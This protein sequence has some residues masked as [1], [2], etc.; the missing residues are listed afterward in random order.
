MLLVFVV[1]LFAGCSD[2]KDED[3]TP[4]VVMATESERQEVKTVE[5]DS[6]YQICYDQEESMWLCCYGYDCLPSPEFSFYYIVSPEEDYSAWKG[7]TVSV[8]GKASLYKTIIYPARHY[9]GYDNPVSYKIKYYTLQL[10]K[11]EEWEAPSD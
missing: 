11:I 5:T 10:E 6:Y 3:N 8:S 9:P 1:I 2:D 4:Q 7:K